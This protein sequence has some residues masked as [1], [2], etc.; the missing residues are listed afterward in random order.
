MT[1]FVYSLRAEYGTAHFGGDARRPRL[2]WKVDA[3]PGWQ[4]RQYQVQIKRPGASEEVSPVIESTDQLFVPWPFDDLGSRQR[5]E[6]RVRVWGAQEPTEWSDPLEIEMGLLERS[7]WCASLIRAPR[8]ADGLPCFRHEF[9]VGPRLKSARAYVTAQGVFDLRLNGQPALPD[10]MPP[11]WTSYSS[12]QPY[13]T[14]DI[15]RFLSEGPNA[16]GAVLGDG[17]YRGRLSWGAGVT[18][19]YGE[20]LG[21]IAQIELAYADGRRE[22]IVTDASWKCGTGGLVASSLYDGEIYDARR[23][24]NGWDRPGFDDSNWNAVSVEDLPDARLVAHWRAPV[25]VKDE[26]VPAEEFSSP[27]GKRLVDFGQIVTG[28]LRLEV[29]AARGTTIRLRHAEV[30]ENGELGVRPLRTAKATDEYIC[31][32]EG[33]EIWEPRFTLHGFRYAEI[34]SDADVKVVA[35]ICYTDFA[36]TGRFACSNPLVTKLHENVSWSLRGNFTH[37]PT[38]CAQRDER[39]GWAGDA[40]MIAPAASFMFDAD[41]FYTYWLEDIALDQREDGTVPMV[42]PEVP[43][44]AFP[45]SYPVTGWGDAAALLPAVLYQRF[46]DRGV[47]ERQWQSAARWAEAEALEVLEPG[48]HVDGFQFGDWLDPTA[49]P[50][51]PEDGR[52]DQRIVMA[53]NAIRSCDAV[54]RAAEVIGRS[55]DAEH[56]KEKSTELR[57]TFR[58]R[59]VTDAGLVVSDSQSGLAMALAYDVLP[60]ALRPAAVERLVHVINRDRKALRVGMLGAQVLLDVLTDAGHADLAY[61]LLLREE[62]PSWLY[63]VKMG[64]TTIWE[65]WDSMLPDGSINPGDMT[66]FSHYAFGAVADWIQ[67]RIGG[68]AP[69]AP[70]Y[71]VIRF[72]PMP[73][74]GI[75]WAEASLD[76]PYG[77]VSSQWRIADGTLDLTVDVPSGTTGIVSSPDDSVEETVGPGI[78]RFSWAVHSGNSAINQPGPAASSGH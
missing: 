25:V 22:V 76:S 64:A 73:G 28:R 40:L 12:R 56:F 31:S 16:V 55:D 34:E 46:G 72:S 10:V 51:H 7:D 42:I 78:H 77:K 44:W 38:D 39:L 48:S 65:R 37:V 29:A 43:L 60:P 74:G 53:I 2:S 27:S 1:T 49:P 62:V 57:K 50:E 19:V 6:I 66:S 69:A 30:L 58:K 33:T 32:G 8:H 26:R 36:T 4:A 63:A 70:G 67:R 5:A 68:I 9:N 71:R 35:R 17:W 13:R 14:V 23:E 75:D 54:A 59:Y 41:A 47:L 21:L 15:G 3:D 45:G 20:E 24:S 18:N 11:G 61:A 52:T